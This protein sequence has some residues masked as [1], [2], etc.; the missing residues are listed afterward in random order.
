M[1]VP[2]RMELHFAVPVSKGPPSEASLSLEHLCAASALSRMIL[3]G[4]HAGLLVNAI[5]HRSFAHSQKAAL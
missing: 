2:V 5:P 4:K 1:L 3:M